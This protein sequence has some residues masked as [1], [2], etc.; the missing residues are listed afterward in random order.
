M[1]AVYV[2]AGAIILIVGMLIGGAL[3]KRWDK[4]KLKGEW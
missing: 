4:K 2:G 1:T 3:A